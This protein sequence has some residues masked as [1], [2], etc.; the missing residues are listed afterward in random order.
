MSVRAVYDT[1]VFVQAA[2]RPDR[3]HATMRAIDE[4]RIS[5]CLSRALLDE[6][7]DV[8]NRK[9]V[10]AKFPTLTPDVARAFTSKL[11]GRSMIFDLVPHEFTWPQHPDDDHV[12]NLAI[13]SQ[14]KYLVTWESRI[15]KLGTDATPDANRLRD[16]APQL[17]I[18][19]PKQL[20]D[21]LRV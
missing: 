15:L 13:C 10:Q 12:F 8:L 18:I 11:I 9:N 20:A 14:A 2:A 4:L 1:M 7:H 21:Q 5:L 19:T 16:L 6:I 17:A 3:V